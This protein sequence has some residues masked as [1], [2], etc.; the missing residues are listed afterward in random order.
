VIYR[1][2]WRQ[3]CDDDGH[4]LRRGERVAVCA[5]TFELLTRE[6]YADQIVPVPP[7]EAIPPEARRPFD[8]SRTTPRDPR[9]TKGLAYDDTTDGATRCGP[10]ES[11]C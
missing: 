3:V 5:K 7:R 2:P 8:C 1:G 9:E 11:C 4:V 6:P 10:G